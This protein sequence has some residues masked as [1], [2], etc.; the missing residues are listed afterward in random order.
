MQFFLI[1]L[2]IRFLCDKIIV[3]NFIE[4]SDFFK[5]NKME[6]RIYII[7]AGF[8]GQTIADDIKRKKIF[9]KVN[10]FI[11]D[12]KSL[13]GTDIDGIPVLGPI[14]SVASVL[15]NSDMQL[16]IETGEEAYSNVH[17]SYFDTIISDDLYSILKEEGSLKMIVG[18]KDENTYD[19]VNSVLDDDVYCTIANNYVVQI[20]SK[21]AT[22]W[23]GV[24]KV[25]ELFGFDSSECMYFGDDFDDVKPIEKC[26]CGVA[27]ENAIAECR[28]V[29]NYICKTNEEDGVAHFIDEYL[30]GG[31]L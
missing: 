12:D 19:M 24:F 4:R 8:A 11:D 20:M 16:T 6:K 15:N 5:A 2:R 3:I 31:K 14:G 28:E 21:E 17:L 27:V 26:G 30:F 22:K 1:L 7:G 23:N 18:I 9:G 25:I 29:S 13:I 10:A